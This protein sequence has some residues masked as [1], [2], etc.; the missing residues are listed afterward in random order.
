M[1]TNV[2]KA[3]PARKRGRPTGS[4]HGTQIVRVLRNEI[5]K[6]F[7]LLNDKNKPIHVLIAREIEQD[8]CKSLNLL[9]KF[10]PQE[11]TFDN[12]GSEF[13]LALGQV[14]DKINEQNQIMRDQAPDT[15]DITPK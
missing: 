11:V 7:D 12:V 6:S 2:N 1:V 5:R 10:L 14:A 13:A 4:G 9:A 15:I 3:V 8:A